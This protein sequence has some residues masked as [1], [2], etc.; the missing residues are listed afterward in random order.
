ML[1]N[2]RWTRKVKSKQNVNV[3]G[4]ESVV[5]MW[6]GGGGGGTPGGL[7]EPAGLS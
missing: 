4:R 7:E 6:G 5:H 2:N 3:I 1:E